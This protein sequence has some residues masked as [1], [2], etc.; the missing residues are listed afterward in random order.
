MVVQHNL[1]AMNAN[2]YLGIN[3]NKLSKSLEKLS[4]GYKINRAG[5][6]AAGLAVS[7]KMR[8][9]IAGM[10]QGVKNAQAGI[11]MVQTYEGALTE[12]DSI[13]QRMKVLAD[14]M[15]NGSYDNEVDRSAAQLEFSQLNDELNQIADTDYNGVIVLNGGRMADGTVIDN[16]NKL[17]K[18]PD[19][20]ATEA[21]SANAMFKYSGAN[22]SPVKATYA[23][24]KE[25][26]TT[27][28][29]PVMIEFNG[30][31]LSLNAGAN[32]TGAFVNGTAATDP[33]MSKLE[34]TTA[35]K[36][37]A[38]GDGFSAGG[39]KLTQNIKAE[40][41]T[42][43]INGQAVVGKYDIDGVTY[44]GDAATPTKLYD[45]NGVEVTIA[46]VVASMQNKV[47]A[48]ADSGVTIAAGTH[49]AGY[50]QISKTYDLTKYEGAKDEGDVVV[51]ESNTYDNA[52]RNLT[53]ADSITLQVGAR[54]KDAVNFTFKYQSDGIGDLTADLDCSARGL[55]TDQLNINTQEDANYAI[56]QI[57][58][59]IN[60]VS[61]VR[62]TFGAV[63]NRLEHKIDNL[64]VSVENLTDAE[65]KIRDTNMAEEMM[66]FTKNNILAQASQSMLAQAN[67]LP[68]SVLSL[69]Q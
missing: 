12:T 43:E 48:A 2:R 19:V 53:Y 27:N 63:Q 55:G 18:L 44:Y 24:D 41:F 14:Q 20:G 6:D 60:K 67:Q 36:A 38:G 30:I 28:D 1:T 62:A 54:S 68:Q 9:Q 58:N 22:A 56:D 4:S 46:N 61:M 45:E 42:G 64:N 69:L 32:T 17:S 3:N 15:A 57:D 65:S 29:S 11:S 40:D 39:I 47:G 34:T 37:N 7:E 21:S 8:S 33:G 23:V 59:A 26:L 50:L 16:A 31:K 51:S 49:G 5:D 25:N 66:N 52:R 13:L 35:I 10:T